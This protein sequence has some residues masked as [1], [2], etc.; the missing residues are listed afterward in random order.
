ML[1]N[2]FN[3]RLILIIFL[4]AIL[5]LNALGSMPP[6]PNWDE[7]SHAYNAYSIL[8]TGKDEW[9]VSFPVI[10]RAYGDYK[11]PIYIYLTAISEFFGGMNVFSVRL[12]SAL[13]GVGTVI[14]TYFLVLSF[15]KL[16]ENS[17]RITS[18]NLALFSAFLVTVEPWSLFLSRGAFE[19][20]LALFFFVLG[21]FFLCKSEEKEIFI[22]PSIISFGLTVWTYN[23]YRVFTPIFLVLSFFIF[24][25]RFKKFKRKSILFGIL[26][27]VLFF[28]PMFFQLLSPQGHA[29]F[30][31]VSILDQGLISDIIN[32]REVSKLPTF[33]QRII[34]NRPVFWFKRFI[35]NWL[36]HYSLGFLFL[37]GGDNF[38]FSVPNHGLLYL[39]EFPFF[40]LGLFLV[41]KFL[42]KGEV[43]AKFII[44]W[45][46]FSPIPSSLTREA[47]H[48]ARA[49]TMLPVPMILTAFGF[50]KFVQYL[51]LKVNKSTSLLFVFIWILILL[52]SLENYLN[53]YLGEYRRN[54][55]WAWQYGYEEVVR[56]VK[57]NYP[58]YDFIVL[59]KKYGEPHEFLLF[60]LNWDPNKL[61]A[62]SNLNRF[63]KSDWFWVDAF[64]KFYFVNDWQ[65]V[66]KE[67]NN[68]FLESGG[69][70]DC[71]SKKCLLITSPGNAPSGWKFIEEVKFLNQETAFQVYEN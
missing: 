18:E 17:H 12:I 5:R 29:R 51:K 10:F 7:V 13:S 66:G 32:K 27:A 33:L 16:F 3:P 47:P 65:I 42:V 58:S 43:F 2:S 40:I 34:Y 22:I 38:Q 31:K 68:F 25:N 21:T 70:V 14:F 48:V 37:K 69:V 52:F 59:T 24:R 39:L 45:L 1:R 67:K 57:E 30:E 61:L 20:N 55:S 11:L 44:S 63:E 19:A 54:Y 26:L 46:L 50:L 15:A 64:D 49:I 9:G 6:S 71:T 56:I 23:S 4:A 36:S 62:D 53:L 41:I 60:Y 8:K 35:S 28:A